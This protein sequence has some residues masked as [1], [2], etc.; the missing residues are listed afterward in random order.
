MRFIY[1]AKVKNDAVLHPLKYIKSSYM[2]RK[3][4]SISQ[5]PYLGLELNDD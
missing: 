5:A 4:L 1:T 3:I 2:I